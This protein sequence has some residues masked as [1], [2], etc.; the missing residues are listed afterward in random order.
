MT[1]K[2]IKKAAIL[3]C[4]GDPDNITQT[5]RIFCYG[6]HTFLGIPGKTAGKVKGI[7]AVP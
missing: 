7:P 4:A 3:A 2:R 1:T 5:K 6:S